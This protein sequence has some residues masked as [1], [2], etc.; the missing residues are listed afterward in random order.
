VYCQKWSPQT[1]STRRQPVSNPL[2]PGPTVRPVASGPLFEVKRAMR[3]GPAY[4]GMTQA[5]L[6]CHP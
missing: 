1:L 4:T 2:I 3:F 5:E 6:T